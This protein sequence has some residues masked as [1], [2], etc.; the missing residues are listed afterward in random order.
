MKLE[1]SREEEISGIK[2]EVG[3]RTQ[4]LRITG[5]EAEKMQKSITN[6]KTNN[7]Q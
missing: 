5:R 4:R 1:K 3:Y 2:K 7:K 6:Q